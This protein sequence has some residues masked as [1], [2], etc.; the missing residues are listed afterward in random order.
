MGFLLIGTPQRGSSL[1]APLVIAAGMILGTTISSASPSPAVAR[2]DAPPGRLHTVVSTTSGERQHARFTL[3]TGPS[4]LQLGNTLFVTATLRTPD[5]TPLPN[6]RIMFAYNA[7]WNHREIVSTDDDGQAIWQLPIVSPADL[8]SS[9]FVPGGGS[10]NRGTDYSVHTIF[11]GDERYVREE[12]IGFFKIASAEVPGSRVRFVS[13]ADSLSEHEALTVVGEL[14]NAAGRPLASEI[15]RLKAFGRETMCWTAPD[16]R[17]T[18]TISP[19][20]RPAGNYV[21]T[22]E[23]SGNGTPASSGSMTNRTVRLESSA[24][25][26]PRVPPLT[27]WAWDFKNEDP[28]QHNYGPFGGTWAFAWGELVSGSL[29]RLTLNEL[30][31]NDYLTRAR[32]MTITMPDGT[33]RPKPI[34]SGIMLSNG[35]TDRSP[36]TLRQQRPP[37]QIQ[38]TSGQGSCPARELPRYDDPLYQSWYAATARA[39]ADYYQR[40]PEYHDVLVGWRVL[41][42]HD[43]EWAVMFKNDSAYP[44][45][46]Y[47]TLARK[48]VTEGEWAAF[49]RFALEA[50]ASAFESA[51]VE[52]ILETYH[53]ADARAYDRPIGSK[54]NAADIEVASH[55]YMSMNPVMGQRMISY[56]WAD[57]STAYESRYEPYFMSGTPDLQN[58]S[59]WAGTYWMIL[60]MLE[61]R[62]DWIDFHPGHWEAYANIPG[63]SQFVNEHLGQSCDTTPS[64]WIVLREVADDN[65]KEANGLWSSGTYGDYQFCLYR[66]QVDGALASPVRGTDLPAPARRQYFTNPY[67]TQRD[68]TG[69]ITALPGYSGRKTDQGWMYF[70]IDDS[71]AHG[72]PNPPATPHPWR[73]NV[74]YLDAGTD[75]WSLRYTGW[76]G[77][78]HRLDVTKTNSGEWR[79]QAWTVW[80]LFANNQWPHST[81]FALSDNGDGV[82]VFHRL[83]VRSTL[84]RAWHSYSIRKTPTIDGGLDDWG[85]FRPLRLDSA[86]AS[87]VVQ[88]TPAPDEAQAGLRTTWD[89]R[90]LYFAVHIADTQVVSDA[91]DFAQ[92]DWIELDLD[93]LH[94]HA[95]LGADDH[96][97]AVSA[98]GEVRDNGTPGGV[99]TATVAGVP[100]GWIAEIA[101][102]WALLGAAPGADRRLGFTW[103]LH[104]VDDD[105]SSRRLVWE[106][107]ETDSSLTWG[108]LDLK[109]CAI[110]GDFDGDGAINAGDFQLLGQ[111]WRQPGAA[112]IPG[113]SADLN[114]DG[115]VSVLDLLTLDRYPIRTCDG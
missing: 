93:G 15:L 29:D 42:G 8:K 70:D 59:Y 68:A 4:S 31:L 62:A 30:L 54:F 81:D 9:G 113:T 111:Q 71:Y 110:P 10:Q 35:Y 67:K 65:T 37:Y 104:D 51:P 20:G 92:N 74:V 55:V 7:E 38:P 19:Q 1:L 80:D 28:A 11:F 73:I 85:D 97:I 82:E 2:R 17:C 76:D 33:Q 14:T 91:L 23:Y 79:E 96:R 34:I 64:A 101:V 102:P 107:D 48:Y 53:D 106:G 50:W 36:Q 69:Q 52:L 109:A 108:H 5:G 114:G 84:P 39:L 99:V 60:W 43:G 47:A 12:L 49:K 13:L 95:A 58:P 90:A 27:Y 46:D 22:L 72:D 77:A 61:S 112:G 16:G 88:G 45:C 24:P 63:F 32:Q 100:D 75:T 56:W 94:D 6:R 25:P 40:H 3:E 89:D 41:A 98:G 105:G 86:G 115:I 103:V 18:L 83:Q 57:Q 21:V 66:P 78:E 44:H 26:P 87:T